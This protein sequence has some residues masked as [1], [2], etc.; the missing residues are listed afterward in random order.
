MHRVTLS[1]ILFCIIVSAPLIAQSDAGAGPAAAIG[2]GAF[3]Q[4]PGV[5]SNPL[6]QPTL[7]PGTLLL[8]ELEGRFSQ[9]V[10]EGGGKA[11][12]SWF[13]DDGVTLNNGKPAILG[14]TAIAAQAQWDPK[15]Y[16]L[17]WVP[18]GAQ[19]GPSNDMGFTWGHYEGRSKDKNGEP[20]V[21]SG[22]YFTVWKKL[23]NGAWKVALDA[24]ADEPAA[25]GEC[26]VL[27]KP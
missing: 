6:S 21:I 9:A 11:F 12:S 3:A 14:R 17:S 23:P 24:S 8:L 22:R 19:M 10:T 1:S 20:V 4:N 5:I 2:Y 27:P 13:A 7:T 15:T 26:C 25:T 18:Q 16:Q